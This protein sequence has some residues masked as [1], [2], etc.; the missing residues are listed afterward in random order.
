MGVHNHVGRPRTESRLP[1]IPIMDWIDNNCWKHAHLRGLEIGLNTKFWTFTKEKAPHSPNNCEKRGLILSNRKWKILHFL[2]FGNKWGVCNDWIMRV[3]LWV[4]L[5]TVGA[6]KPI[7]VFLNKENGCEHFY[8]KP[9]LVFCLIFKH[10]WQLI[11]YQWCSS[12][13]SNLLATA[14]EHFKANEPEIPLSCRRQTKIKMEFQSRVQPKTQLTY[15]ISDNCTFFC[16][17]A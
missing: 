3:I 6:K 2:P 15:S 7:K 12:N 1:S 13:V 9:H 5:Q 17:C 14:V 8:S 11:L 10:T 4:S 16:I